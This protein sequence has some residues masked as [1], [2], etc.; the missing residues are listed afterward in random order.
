MD[1][2]LHVSEATP[3]IHF[4]FVIVARNKNGDLEPALN[5]GLKQM[6]IQRPDLSAPESKLNNPL[7]TFSKSLRDDFY[8]EIEK[9][10]FK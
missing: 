10:E 9:M 6:G 5:R 8:S 2:S 1:Y 7:M 3:H 4:R